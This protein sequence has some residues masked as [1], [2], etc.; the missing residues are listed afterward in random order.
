MEGLEIWVF[1]SLG[2]LL[3]ILGGDYLRM[4]FSMSEKYILKSDCT[5]IQ[6]RCKNEIVEA[7][8]TNREDHRSL[9]KK[10]DDMNAQIFEIVKG[11]N[12]LNGGR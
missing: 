3:F 11:I 1:R 12:K 5:L 7:M 6:Q 10:L 2:A 4:R 9:F 8:R